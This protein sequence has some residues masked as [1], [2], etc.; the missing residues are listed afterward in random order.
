MTNYP[1]QSWIVEDSQISQ[2]W[3]KWFPEWN[4]VEKWVPL[5]RHRA[6]VLSSNS[7]MDKKYEAHIAQKS[8]RKNECA[9]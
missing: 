4:Q 5:R 6:H 9:Q 7:V 1:S 2:K 3:Q 8:Q